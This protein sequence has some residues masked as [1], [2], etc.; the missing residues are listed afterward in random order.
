MGKNAL[1]V[2]SDDKEWRRRVSF[3]FGKGSLESPDGFKDLSIGDE[4]TVLVTGKVN[5]LNQNEDTSSFALQMEK[6]ELQTGTKGGLSEALGKAKK[7]QKV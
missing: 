7:K 3:D 1:E 6:I 4:V 5:S 2:S